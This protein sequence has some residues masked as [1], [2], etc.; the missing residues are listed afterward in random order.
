MQ[1]QTKKRSKWL[2]LSSI[3]LVFSLTGCGIHSMYPAKP[4]VWPHNFW[5]SVLQVVSHSIDFFAHHLWGSYGLAL[6]AVT[7]IVRIIVLPFFVKQM[8]HTRSMQ[9]IQPEIQ[10]IRAK[11]KGDNQ[12]IQQETSKLWQQHGV[13]PMAGCFPMLIQMPVLYALFGAI[14]GNV[15][16]NNSTFLGIFQLGTHDHTYILPIVAAI[17]TY[18]SSRVMMT[19]ND[20]QQKMMLFIMPVFIFFIGSRMPAGL[21]LYWIYTNVFTAAQGYFVKVR[22]VQTAAAAGTVAAGSSGGSVGTKKKAGQIPAKA[23]GNNNASG[24]STRSKSTSNKSAGNK[25]TGSKGTGNKS[26]GNKSAGSKGAGTKN[27]KGTANGSNRTKGTSS[28]DSGSGS[29]SDTGASESTRETSTTQASTSQT[30]DSSAGTTSN[31]GS[32]SA[33]GT[34]NKGSAK[35][36]GSKKQGSSARKEK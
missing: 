3:V 29:K 4:G 35:S 12:K 32:P 30:G 9:A 14:E 13:N 25:N 2:W 11:Y 26:T 18:L 20:S 19:G 17:T 10:K 33:S 31:S 15:P 34:S 8:R 23:A 21:A 5:G 22:P 24:K 28:G 7:V 6:L 36:S 16:L 1:S 27:S